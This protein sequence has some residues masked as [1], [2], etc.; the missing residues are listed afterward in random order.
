LEQ[1]LGPCAEAALKERSEEAESLTRAVKEGLHTLG[2]WR[3][4]KGSESLDPYNTDRPESSSPRAIVEWLGCS[5]HFPRSPSI[6]RI[7]NAWT[8]RPYTTVTADFE[9]ST[10]LLETLRDQAIFEFALANARGNWI[11]PPTAINH[12]MPKQE[13]AKRLMDAQSQRRHKF[14][15]AIYDRELMI[16]K[17]QLAKFYGGADWADETPGRTWAE[18]AEMINKYTKVNVPD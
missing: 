11:V 12:R 13:F 7:V 6:D 2:I 16:W 9:Y 17:S 15:S 10:G 5:S 4:A 1:H 14:G 18:I 8:N 3:R